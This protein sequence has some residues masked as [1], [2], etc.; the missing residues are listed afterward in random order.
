[1]SEQPE[2]WAVEQHIK[3]NPKCEW[4]CNHT[5]QENLGEAQPTQDPNCNCICHSPKHYAPHKTGHACCDEANVIEDNSL[6]VKTTNIATP[7]PATKPLDELIDEIV[8]IKGYGGKVAKLKSYPHAAQQ[9]KA[10]IANE[11]ATYQAE[12]LKDYE[13]DVAE[14]V[15]D[16]EKQARLDELQ[17][18]PLNPNFIAEYLDDRIKDLEQS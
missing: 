15:A 12:L 14:R 5:N 3:R 2:Q 7:T 16:A 10:L 13:A 9:I 4:L 17:A 1:M 6:L 8:V 18:I 11:M